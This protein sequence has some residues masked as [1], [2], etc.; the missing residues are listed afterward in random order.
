M[1]MDPYELATFTSGLRVVTSYY[2]L[3]TVYIRI[4]TSYYDVFTEKVHDFL[5]VV[6]Y[7]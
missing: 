5:R 7:N 2:D 6:T 3:F 4:I 1:L